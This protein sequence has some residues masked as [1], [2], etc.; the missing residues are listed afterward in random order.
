MKKILFLFMF[1]LV[2]FFIPVFNVRAADTAQNVFVSC[3]DA[4]VIPDPSDPKMAPYAGLLVTHDQ[5]TFFANN[6]LLHT[7]HVWA[8]PST[9]TSYSH[10]AMLK[11]KISDTTVY[12]F[13]PTKSVSVLREHLGAFTCAVDKDGVSTCPDEAVPTASGAGNGQ[14]FKVLDQSKDAIMPTADGSLTINHVMSWTAQ[15]LN[16]NFYGMQI[17]TEMSGTTQ[18]D[19]IGNSLKLATFAP[20]QSL[21]DAATNCVSVQWDPFGRVIDARTLEPV[22]NVEVTLFNQEGSSKVQTVNPRN[23]VFLNPLKTY[24]DGTF[25]FAVPGG[26]YYLSPKSADFTFP[27]DDA[28]LQ[29]VIISLK[30]LDPNG[31]YI[32]TNKLYKSVDEAIVEKE[33]IAERRDIVLV[34]KDVNYAGSTAQI[35]TKNVVH[36]GTNYVIEGMV[37]HPKTVVRALING[38][39][40]TQIE[41]GVDREYE[42]TIPEAALPD[43]FDGIFNLELQKLP[44]V[45]TATIIP[46]QAKTVALVAAMPT[47][48]S[49]FAIGKDG[50]VIA[51]AVIEI[52]IPKLANTS[53]AFT[54]ADADGFFVFN[55]KRL[56][57]FPFIVRFTDPANPENKFTLSPQEF[58]QVNKSYFAETKRNMYTSSTGE[59]LLASYKPKQELVTA[60]K[61]SFVRTV[62][63]APESPTAM[64]TEI[65]QAVAQQN[66]LFPLFAFL[67]VLMVGAAVGLVVFLKKPKQMV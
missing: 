61:E 43:G 65:A 37:S 4:Y 45:S 46:Q 15:F 31:T 47:S 54:N 66:A 55:G 7:F 36:D 13:T 60:L 29:Q 8:D 19:A 9:G 18:T 34:P 48:I 40:K 16:Q 5:E 17:L 30:T 25:N 3:L 57:Q 44:L 39:V 22:Q 62:T 33:G 63:L 12:K 50:K 10:V 6:G 53:Y 14:D 41:T 1:V 38:V 35:E 42:L 51:R 27:A 56:P 28:T 20:Q 52:V 26:T 24:A 2:V 49:G 67:I 21:P 59:I 64:P 58:A 23:P 11:N 32:D